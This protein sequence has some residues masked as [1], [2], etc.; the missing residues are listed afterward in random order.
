MRQW[1]AEHPDY[2]SPGLR[3]KVELIRAAKNKPCADCGI[4]YP[5]YVMQF[6]HTRLKR[7]AVSHHTTSHTLESIKTEIKKCDVVC[8]NCHAERT[9]KR[10]AK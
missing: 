1:C 7:F 6:D 2:I 3:Q 5:Y 10:H 9:H 8:A 4:Y